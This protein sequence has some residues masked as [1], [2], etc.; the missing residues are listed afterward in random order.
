M[1]KG[2][3]QTHENA[4][5]KEAGKYANAIRIVENGMVILV[6]RLFLIMLP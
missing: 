2:N 3:D 1:R 6:E 4:Q 5:T